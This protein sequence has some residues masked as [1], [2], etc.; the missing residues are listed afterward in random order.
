MPERY[1]DLWKASLELIE[2]HYL[3]FILSFENK[4]KMNGGVKLYALFVFELFTIKT[5]NE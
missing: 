3:F 5:E 1:R 2:N 4:I